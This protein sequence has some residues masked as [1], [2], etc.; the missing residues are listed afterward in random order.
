[1]PSGSYLSENIAGACRSLGFD[2][3]LD[4]NFSADLTI[5]EEAHELQKKIEGKV[6]LPLFTSCCPAWVKYVEI[7]YPSLINHLSTTRSPIVM[8]GAMVKTYF[9]QKNGIDPHNIIHVAIA[10]CTAKKYEITRE[11]LTTNGMRSTDFVITTNELSIMLN[12]RNID[13]SAG[14]GSFDSLMGTASGGG[15]LFG[16]TGGVMA[17]AIRT[18][19]FNITGKNPPMNLVE[20]NNI[21]G[22][23]GIKSAEV[24]IDGVTLKVAVCYEMRNAQLLLEQVKD[25][26]CEYDFIEVMSCPGGCVGGAGQPALNIANLE[27]RIRALESADSRATT[28]FCHEN[29]EVISIYKEF[30]GK[31]GGPVAEQYLHTHY[32]DKSD[33]LIPVLEE[34]QP[35]P[36]M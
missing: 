27:D 3:V 26:T 32:F 8:Q 10:P 29:P 31:P 22:L 4:T 15:K 18:A 23:S 2:Y 35:E 34:R 14:K 12:S 25:G 6:N 28:R 1:M 7:F 11:E 5:M 13:F 19:H 33:L 21:W 9:A 36:V 24:N 17:A 16:N 30:L 20:L